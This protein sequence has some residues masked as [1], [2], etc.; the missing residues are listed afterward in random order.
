MGAAPGPL[1]VDAVHVD[2]GVGALERAVPPLLDRGKRLLAEVRDGR[3][4]HAGAPENLA[5]VL[6]PPGRDAR[7]V[8]LNHGLL[9][10]GLPALVALD[11]RRC[12]PHALELGLR[13]VT[14]PDDVV[15]LRS[16]WP[17]R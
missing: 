4:R 17:A 8:H 5:R 13:R 2:V 9:D 16:W 12:E 10:G 14:S 1:E 3:R 6:N 15:R 7:E 11:D